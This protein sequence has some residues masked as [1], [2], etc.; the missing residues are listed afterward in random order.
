MITYEPL[1]DI[2]SLQSS[3]VNPNPEPHRRRQQL[4]NIGGG[5]H[6]VAVRGRKICRLGWGLERRFMSRP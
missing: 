3:R 5:G 4:G 2:V 1:R 6:T